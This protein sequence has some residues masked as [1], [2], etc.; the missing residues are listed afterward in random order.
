MTTSE[1]REYFNNKGLSCSDINK[2]KIDRLETILKTKLDWFKNDT[3]TM[4][5]NKIKKKQIKFN[6]NGE[7]E[8]CYFTVRGYIDDGFNKKFKHFKEREA[9]SFNQK[10]VGCEIFIGFA[11]WADSK[12]IKPFI[13]A[14]KLWVDEMSKN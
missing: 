4:K 8:C 2:E 9:I 6:N 5:L 11:G 13:E 10:H 7:L 1:L 14:F 12:N 3:F